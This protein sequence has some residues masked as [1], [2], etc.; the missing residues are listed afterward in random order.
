MGIHLSPELILSR[1]P[2]KSL[3]S[4][5]ESIRLSEILNESWVD[6]NQL[7]EGTWVG[8]PKKVTPSEDTWVENPKKGHTKWNLVGDRLLNQEYNYVMSWIESIFHKVFESWVDLNQNSGKSFE[9][10]VDL[11]QITENHFESWVVLNQ[12]LKAIVSHELSQ[13]KKSEPE[14]NQIEKRVLPMSV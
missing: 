9:W 7:A 4:W 12:F 5:V 6:W 8:S 14:L 2:G 13:N 10:W 1:F 3:E 11:N